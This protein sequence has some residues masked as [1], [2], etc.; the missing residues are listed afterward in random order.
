VKITISVL[1]R[2][3]LFYLAKQLQNHNFLSKLITSYPK[4]EAARYG[5]NPDNVDSLLFHEIH[6]RAWRKISRYTESF[7]NPQYMIFELFDHH[8]ARHILNHSDIF[9]G[10][11]GVSLYSLRRASQMGMKTILERGS[12]HMLYQRK[13]LDEEYARFGIRKMVVHPQVV[14]RELREYLEADFIAIPSHFVKETFLQQGIA[15][16]KLIHIPFGVDLTH[17]YPA[18]KQDKTFR[19]IHCGNISLRKGVHYLLQAFSELNLPRA[20]L[21]LIG[22]L[23][24]EIKP[25]WQKWASPAIKHQGPFPENHLHRYYSQGS[26][27]CLASIEDGFG[28]VL[29][30][31]MACGLPVISTTNT[32]GADI[33]R[34][35]QEGF[36]VPIRDVEAIKEKILYFYENPEACKAIGESARKR[37]QAGFSW[38]DYGR[39]MIS[40]YQNILSS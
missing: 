24:D 10:L 30:Q 26:V 8:A 18:P 21:W 16:E 6:N 4:F 14:E 11:S 15:A 1:G 29:I 36:V 25:F 23:A 38:S 3:W 2:F 12:T 27:F 34:E 28:M 7:F 22:S 17:F 37:V 20:E 19:I 13:I 39:Q 32:G 35:G 33:I 31:A 40:T 9:V 5:I